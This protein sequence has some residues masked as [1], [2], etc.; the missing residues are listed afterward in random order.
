[1]EGAASKMK[2]TSPLYAAD[3]R[4][5]VERSRAELDTILAKY[6]ATARAFAVDDTANRAKLG[7]RIAGLEYRM[8][9][10]LPAREPPQTPRGWRGWPESRRQEWLTRT[11][12]QALRSRWRVLLLLVKAKLEAVSL[13]LSTVEK[14][15]IADLVLDDGRT[16]Y[17][18]LGERIQQALTGASP[19]MLGDGRP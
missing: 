15:F 16:V 1:M 2:E 18:A 12:S 10:P 17:S 3:T 8:E 9:V 14:E 4:V 6:G 11:Q 13:G 19:L 5:P 7:F